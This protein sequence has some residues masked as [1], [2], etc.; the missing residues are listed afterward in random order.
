[1]KK[2]LGRSKISLKELHKTNNTRKEEFKKNH[3]FE[4]KAPDIQIS[5]GIIV[6]LPDVNNISKANENCGDE[7]KSVTVLKIIEHKQKIC[8][9]K[10]G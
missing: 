1:M 3:N 6:K 8:S 5:A 4:K 7:Y 2:T 9:E 10:T